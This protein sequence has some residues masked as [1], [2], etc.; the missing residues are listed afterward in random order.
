MRRQAQGD[1][2]LAFQVPQGNL[3][4]LDAHPERP[5][6]ETPLERP[7]EAPLETGFR[8]LRRGRS[9]NHGDSLVVLSNECCVV[10]PT[11]RDV[12]PGLALAGTGLSRSPGCLCSLMNL[13]SSHTRDQVY[14]LNEATPLRSFTVLNRQRPRAL[15]QRPTTFR[16][17]ELYAR[18]WGAVC[19]VASAGG[20]SGRDDEN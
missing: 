10:P 20:S 15:W 19:R 3:K 14:L 11:H 17:W 18:R 12:K 7:S 8:R 4:L 13:Q 9:S 16:R 2:L 5:H 6:R 1:M